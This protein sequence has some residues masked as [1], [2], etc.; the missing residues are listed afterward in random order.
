[1]A[2]LDDYLLTVKSNSQAMMRSYFKLYIIPALGDYKVEKI[3]A[4]LLQSI[5]NGWAKRAN[6]ASLSKGKRPAGSC[7]NY[8]LILS[9]V[10]RILDFAFQMGVISSNPARMVVAPRLKAR[11]KIK[12]SISIMLN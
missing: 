1:M 2:W 10:R 11:G 8:T 5:V 7:R 3:T 9:T 6:T 4:P 12:S